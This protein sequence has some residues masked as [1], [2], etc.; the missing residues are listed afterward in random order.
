MCARCG[1]IV[2]TAIR[3]RKVLGV[4]VPVWGPGPCRNPECAA[5]VVD[6]ESGE[7]A[8][9][10]RGHGHSHSRVRS[11]GRRDAEGPGVSG[12]VGSSGGEDAPDVGSADAGAAGGR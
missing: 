7:A 4:F 9:R 12:G 10:R 1:Q 5:Y 6:E 8:V 2:G 11:R 3:R